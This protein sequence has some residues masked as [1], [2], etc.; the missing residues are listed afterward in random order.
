MGHGN[1]N[2]MPW[3]SIGKLGIVWAHG[4]GSSVM[5]LGSLFTTR[6]YELSSLVLA[7]SLFSLPLILKEEKQALSQKNRLHF[8]SFG[9]LCGLCDYLVQSCRRK[10]RTGR[11]CPAHPYAR[12]LY[13][14]LCH[15]CHLCHGPARDF[16]LHHAP[17]LW[18]VGCDDRSHS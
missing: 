16:G 3:F 18:A 12:P 15:D 2:N 4:M 11:R 5:V 8:L 13:L 14:R 1:W 7:L 10:R 9:S 17:H 6:I